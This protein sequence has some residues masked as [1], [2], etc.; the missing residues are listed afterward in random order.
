MPQL[1]ALHPV[2]GFAILALAGITTWASWP[3]RRV[4]MPASA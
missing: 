1:A 4:T 2:N 3:G